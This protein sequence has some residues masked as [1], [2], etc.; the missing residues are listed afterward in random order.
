[1]ELYFYSRDA[2]PVIRIAYPREF[3][4]KISDRDPAEALQ[5]LKFAFLS[6]SS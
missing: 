2:I 1:M 4:I 3:Q 5:N 6:S